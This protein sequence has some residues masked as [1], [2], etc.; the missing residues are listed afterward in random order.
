MPGYTTPSV[1]PL[2]LRHAES[3]DPMW[4]KTWWG[5]RLPD[6]RAT[7]CSDLVRGQDYRSL[8]APGH[9]ARPGYQDVSGGARPAH[10]LD[11]FHRL[12]LDRDARQQ[13]PSPLYRQHQNKSI[14]EVSK[15]IYHRTVS[16]VLALVSP[17][18]ATPFS[19]S[20]TCLLVS[21]DQLKKIFIMETPSFLPNRWPL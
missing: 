14:G 2:V 5:H 9:R 18:G 8:S 3:I 4:L 11:E 19:T 7:A 1:S 6:P 21:P 12:F 13:S 17:E 15:R 16:S 10:R 20:A